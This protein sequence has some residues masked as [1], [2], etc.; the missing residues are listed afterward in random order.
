[1]LHEQRG[2][3]P[4]SRHTSGI[5]SL[6]RQPLP[7]GSTLP[8]NIYQQ[9]TIKSWEQCVSR[10]THD[11]LQGCMLP[12]RCMPIVTAPSASPVQMPL[13][14]KI[15]PLCVPCAAQRTAQRTI[16]ACLCHFRCPSILY[17]AHCQGASPFSWQDS[18]VCSTLISSRLALL[19]ARKLI[20]STVSGLA[21]G[22]TTSQCSVLGCL[23]EPPSS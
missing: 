13:P 20:A 9:F 7:A 12:W 2:D 15:I 23:S 14:S 16:S 21:C 11:T 18:R 8:I 3:S 10:C 17:G 6:K 19:Q 1:M 22:Q 5:A 4:K